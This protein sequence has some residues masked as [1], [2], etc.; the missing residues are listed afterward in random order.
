[1]IKNIIF[2]IGDVL[3]RF[4]WDEY[5]HNLFDGNT[6][7]IDAVN[8]AINATGLWIELDRNVIPE[9]EVF[10][11]MRNHNP[12]YWKDVV[13]ALENAGGCFNRTDYAIPWI[14]ELKSKGYKIYFLSNYSLFNLRSAP[15]VVD[16][17]PLTDGGVFSCDVHLLKPDRAIYEEIC[18]KYD[19][20]PSE[21]IFI[22]DRKENVDAAIEYGMEAIQ[23]KG[24]EFTDKQLKEKL[25]K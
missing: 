21:C 2:D 7:T 6:E 18:K 17:L 14:K 23:F 15:E 20:V 24:Y 4:T 25:S 9:E 16:F 22:D 12:K 19:L 13:R 5:I 10:Y 11:R 8:E 1:M 3:M